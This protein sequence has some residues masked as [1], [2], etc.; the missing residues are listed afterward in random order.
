MTLINTDD[1]QFFRV[2][3]FLGSEFIGVDQWLIFF[4]PT[5]SSIEYLHEL[6]T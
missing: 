3:P 4:S 5:I 2:Y 6:T 1:G